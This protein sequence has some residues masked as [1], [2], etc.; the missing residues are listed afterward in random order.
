MTSLNKLLQ[1]TVAHDVA[2]KQELDGLRPDVNIDDEKPA[3][4][5]KEVHEGLR[6]LAAEVKKTLDENAGK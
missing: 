4:V 3:K 5:I 2:L 6:K 1:G